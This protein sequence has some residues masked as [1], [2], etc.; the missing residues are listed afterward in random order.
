[1]IMR[2]A[3]IIEDDFN[4]GVGVG[5]TLFVQG[6]PHHCVGCHNPETWNFEGGKQWENK[7]KSKLLEMIKKP[8]ITRLTISGGEPLYYEDKDNI[9]CL[10]RLIGEVKKVRPDIKIWLY[11]G[12]V[13]EEMVFTQKMI[14]EYVDVLVDGKFK[15]ELKDLSLAFKGSSNQRVIDMNKT[16]K[17]HKIVLYEHS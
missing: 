13:F 11:T 14:I 16:R 7:G 6:C 1:M 3:G 10:L 4:N 5:V 12:Y 9:V 2:Y 8:Y 17:E 15:Q